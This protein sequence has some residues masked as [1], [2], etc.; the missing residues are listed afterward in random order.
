MQVLRANCLWGLGRLPE[1]R[2]IVDLVLQ[3]DSNHVDAL[4]LRAQLHLAENQP[5]SALPLLEKAVKNEPHDVVSRQL[6]VQVFN[7]QGDAARVKEQTRFL[8][9]TKRLKDRLTRLHEE[10]L[11]KPWDDQVRVQI[12]Q[13]CMELKRPAEARMWLEA[14]LASNPNCLE[15]RQR[16][17]KLAEETPGSDIAGK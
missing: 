6:L 2:Q 8:E 17:Q 5:Q 12:A 3:T 15:A 16:L 14:A 13:A 11:K 7:Q 1:A 10:A 9:E 4:R